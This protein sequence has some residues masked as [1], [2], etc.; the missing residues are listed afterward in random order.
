MNHISNMMMMMI[1]FFTN[2]LAN[3]IKINKSGEN[4]RLHIV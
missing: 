1:K 3:I 4:K 2:I